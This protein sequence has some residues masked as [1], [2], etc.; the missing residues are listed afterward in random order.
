MTAQNSTTTRECPNRKDSG[1]RQT[2]LGEVL[3]FSNGR[4]SPERRLDS[5]Y[6][7]YGSN[8]IIGYSDQLNAH[9][10]TIVIGRVGSYCGSLYISHEDCWVTDNAIKAN[11]KGDADPRFMY[12]LMQTLR[13]NDWRTGSGQPL[14]NQA[15]LSSIPASVPE[16]TEQRRIAHILGTLDDKIELNRR[17]NRTLEE[18]ARALFKSWFVDFAPVRAKMDGR[19]RR[20]QSL[21][22]LPADLYDLFPDR[23]APS[24]LGE[25]P[26]GWMVKALGEVISVVGGTTPS[27][28]VEEY[29]EGGT[30]C[31]A[32]PK[33]L[34][35]L[36]TPVL[37][38]TERRITDAG[39]D[40]IGSGLLPAGSLLLSSRAPVGYLAIAETPT[41]INQ[42]FIGIPPQG[43]T[44]LSKAQ[45]LLA[46]LA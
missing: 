25:I 2:T 14:L 11:T 4:S 5:R 18:M 20:G 10:D 35:S 24:E 34:A 42:G 45:P 30:H 16:I 44:S 41:A 29:W 36:D 40:R 6:P 22:G 38:D 17:M 32:T 39:L 43:D 9:H 1:W 28:K 33:D 7:V 19:W 15:T 23:L 3:S 8:G 13:L 37:L 46:I 12:Y 26:A 31:W 21:P 27:T